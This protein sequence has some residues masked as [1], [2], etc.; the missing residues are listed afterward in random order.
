MAAPVTLKYRGFISYSHADTAWAKWLHR[1]LEG[2]RIGKEF[3]GRETA[4]GIVPKVLRPIFRDRDEFTA[5]QA[6]SDQTQAAL[7]ASSALVVLC[8]PAATKSRYVD[9]EVRLFK[10]R[11][12]ERPVVPLIVGGKPGDA[13]EECFP[14]ALKFVVDTDGE[15][16]ETPIELLAAD[17]REEGDG[18][19][20]ALAKV[21]AG[22]L[23]LSSDEVFRRAERELR[24]RQRRWIVGLSTVA[25]LMAGLAVWAEFN[26]REAVT[27]RAE[28]ERN[29]A[30]AKQGAESLVFDIA[31]A[32]R[33]QEG[34]RTETVR[35]ILGM[36]EQVIA[37]L[38]EKSENNLELMHIQSAMLNEFAQTYAAQG[39]TT[40]QDE[41]ARK[42]AAIAERLSV[43]DPGN[44]KW[45]NQLA[46]AHIRIGD[47]LFEHG[48]LDDALKEFQKSLAVAE[49]T[50]KA[51]PSIEEGQLNLAPAYERL[52]NVLDAQGKLTESL[53]AY[54]TSRDLLAGLSE[55]NP[56]NAGW[57]RDLSVVYNKV[58]HVLESQGD[59][60]GALK[61]YQDSLAIRQRLAI[62]DSAN[63]D[64][65][66]GLAVVHERIGQV[67]MAQGDLSG[68]LQSFES[69][70][71]IISRLANID[72]GNAS[73][74][75]DL[76]VATTRSATR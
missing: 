36:A 53:D 59:L 2:F 75:R 70:R 74:Q 64:W 39:D 11:H 18:K 17:A 76:A 37:R 48:K 14:P 20:L 55:G 27:Q 63:A 65:Q 42:A 40:K 21:V 19:S 22:L 72:P 44:F 35:K 43:T 30:V 24:Q 62:S 71:A 73:W 29:F 13:D 38:V 5:G 49:Q 61:N 57:L 32:L 60:A 23:G 50:A 45:Q 34:M 52:G 3:V 26:R 15:I 9:E 47:T 25:L 41:A 4:T 16:T 33:D 66:Y 1:S 7:D 56:T 6:L 69:R 58:G 67:Q 54:R 12:P 10:S 8:S 68:A 28:A 31:Q 46:L 51:H